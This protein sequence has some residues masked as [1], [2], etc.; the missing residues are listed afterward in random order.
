MLANS[1]VTLI[2]PGTHLKGEWANL[3]SRH[4]AFKSKAS[5][6]LIEDTI[7]ATDKGAKP[8]KLKYVFIG[9]GGGGALLLGS[10]YI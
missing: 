5:G 1:P 3:L 9:G 4:D 6:Q 2:Q 7:C 10:I 8:I